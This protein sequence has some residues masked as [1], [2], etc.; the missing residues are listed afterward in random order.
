M[1]ERAPL[2]HAREARGLNRPHLAELMGVS[3]SYIYHVEMGQRD[4]SFAFMRRWLEILGEGATLDLFRLEEDPGT[5]P[6]PEDLP[7]ETRAWL[8]RGAA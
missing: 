4:P 1:V 7:P 8:E 3:R 5:P 2:I 6:D